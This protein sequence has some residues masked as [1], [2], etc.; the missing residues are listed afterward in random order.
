[1]SWSLPGAGPVRTSEI[2]GADGTAVRSVA[3][4]ILVP[5]QRPGSEWE[6]RSESARREGRVCAP[7]STIS[8]GAIRGGQSTG[9]GQTARVW[10]SQ[11]AGLK[12]HNDSVTATAV[13]RIDL[14]QTANVRRSGRDP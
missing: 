6:T 8:L 11:R 1:M 5:V 12:P 7:E 2:Y 4:G 14:A 13:G 9:A 3:N 10:L